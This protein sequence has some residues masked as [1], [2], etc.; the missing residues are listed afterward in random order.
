MYIVSPS[1]NSNYKR[2]QNLSDGVEG[3]V[4]GRVIPRDPPMVTV[5]VG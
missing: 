2:L 1:C 3:S 5:S 4:L